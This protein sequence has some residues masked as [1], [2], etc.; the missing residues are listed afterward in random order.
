MM[1]F[2]LYRLLWRPTKVFYVA[3][4]MLAILAA[5]VFSCIM[6]SLV[7][8]KDIEQATELLGE[9]PAFLFHGCLLAAT[10]IGMVAN[11]VMQV[12]LYGRFSWTLPNLAKRL[13]W[14]LAILASVVCLLCLL[15]SERLAESTLQLPA[16]QGAAVGLLGFAIGFQLWDAKIGR[17]YGFSMLALLFSLLFFSTGLLPIFTDYPWLLPI[18]AIL[19]TGWNIYRSTRRT[20]LRTRALTPTTQLGP[21]FDQSERPMNKKRAQANRKQ[22]HVVW[23]HGCITGQRA[24]LSAMLYEQFGWQRGGWKGVFLKPVIFIF[25]ALALVL[26]FSYHFFPDHLDSTLGGL[27]IGFSMGPLMMTATMK[28]NFHSGLL[29]P[30]SRAQRFH[31]VWKANF[32][33]GLLV[34]GLMACIITVLSLSYRLKAHAEWDDTNYALIFSQAIA[35]VIAI[36]YFQQSRVRLLDTGRLSPSSSGFSSRL[37]LM[38]LLY[39]SLYFLAFLS[40]IKATENPKVWF[41]CVI[42]IP[43]LWVF[44]QVLFRRWL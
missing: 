35:T 36:P 21:S 6:A 33:A 27:S 44:S 5:T 4:A 22:R 19:L 25:S 13:R 18:C 7:A 14:E 11:F 39:M 3:L 37:I 2:A 32:R 26:I 31:I 40:L 17:A 23:G 43:A 28:V 1:Q 38:I 9:S 41:G 12:L 15:L 34:L 16:G 42:G 24:W 20:A 30:I 29:H 10:A 8:G